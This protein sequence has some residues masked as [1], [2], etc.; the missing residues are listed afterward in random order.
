MLL[1][2]PLQAVPN[3]TVQ[4]TLSSQA[5]TI[6]V[7]QLQYGLFVDVLVGNTYVVASAIAENL[8]RLVRAPYTG[9]IGDLA[10]MDTQGTDDPVYTGLGARWQLL[11]DDTGFEANLA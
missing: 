8:N 11:Y 1:A 3:Q 4:C 9:F 5:C 7:Y 6:N 2:I 10:F